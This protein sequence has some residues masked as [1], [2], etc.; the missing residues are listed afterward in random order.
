MIGQSKT[1]GERSEHC[2][3][4]HVGVINDLADAL[5]ED[6]VIEALT[7]AIRYRDLAGSPDVESLLR[8]GGQILLEPDTS[9]D[10]WEDFNGFVTQSVSDALV[11]MRSSDLRPRTADEL[12]DELAWDLTE[13]MCDACQEAESY[14]QVAIARDFISNIEE[15]PGFENAWPDGRL[16]EDDVARDLVEEYGLF[17]DYDTREYISE[18]T[19]SASVLLSAT[20]ECSAERHLHDSI[21]QWHEDNFDLVPTSDEATGRSTWD[22][23]P[24]RE[25]VV[26]PW[27]RPADETQHSSY[28]T[29][30]E[31]Q[32]TTLE[33]VVNGG[34]GAFGWS[35][36]EDLLECPDYGWPAL[37]VMCTMTGEQFVSAAVCMLDHPDTFARRG[38]VGTA[39][40]VPADGE[41]RYPCLIGLFD[42]VNGSGGTMGV[43]L[44]RPL[45]VAA[46]EVW[47]AFQ[48]P[49]RGGQ[50]GGFWTPQETFGLC[51]PFAGRVDD[52]PAAARPCLCHENKSLSAQRDEVTRGWSGSQAPEAE[53]GQE[54]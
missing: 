45:P 28:D 47:L 34:G 10:S 11:A 14:V 37:S 32:G 22:Y 7:D 4:E 31:S 29:L 15:A 21:L 41:T 12:M 40:V 2:M 44:E 46:S 30:C 25:G 49:D 13:K 43:R 26:E 38:P 6:R 3:R 33:E 18:A 36:L 53:I 54:R 19:F 8:H 20:D 5:G 27:R 52:P 35:F 48:E 23:V 42:P 17:F 50:W 39:F 24:T 9:R 16:D 1:A 51:E